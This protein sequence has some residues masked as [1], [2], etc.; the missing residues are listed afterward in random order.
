MGLFEVSARDF[1]LVI[2]EQYPGHT[3]AHRDDLDRVHLAADAIRLA[4]PPHTARSGTVG[5]AE[6]HGL[7][8]GGMLN[9]ALDLCQGDLVAVMDA[10]D[11]YSRHYLTDLSRAFL[12][13]TADGIESL[14]ERSETLLKD[15][16]PAKVYQPGTWGPNSIHQLIAPNAWRLP[17]ER[18]WRENKN[19]DD[20]N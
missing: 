12:F 20:D 1:D 19:G 15:P 2:A 5:L 3:R 17:F 9:H 16:P 13:T 6:G 8:I 4:L 10:Q 18:G 7:T 14:W 11:L